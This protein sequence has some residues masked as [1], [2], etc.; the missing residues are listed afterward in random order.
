MQIEYKNAA[1]PIRRLR[2]DSSENPANNAPAI[3]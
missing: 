2:S 3:K 1:L